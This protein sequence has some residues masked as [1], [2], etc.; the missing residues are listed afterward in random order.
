MSGRVRAPREKSYLL[1]VRGERLMTAALLP[2]AARRGFL[3]ILCKTF[4]RL[5]FPWGPRCTCMHSIEAPPSKLEP[6][7]RH[8]GFQAASLGFTCRSHPYR[9]VLRPLLS[10]WAP[11]GTSCPHERD[12]QPFL[13]LSPLRARVSTHVHHCTQIRTLYSPCGPGF[14]RMHKTPAALGLA[15]QRFAPL[16]L[17]KVPAAQ[18]G[19]DSAE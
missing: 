12:S 17:D 19:V 4:G 7:E 5:S 11:L 13:Q 18:F 16:P 15:G 2:S 8:D 14:A 6:P 9:G 3:I 1:H 10:M